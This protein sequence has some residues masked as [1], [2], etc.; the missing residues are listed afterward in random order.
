MADSGAPAAAQPAVVYVD[1]IFDL[2]H[3]GH[4]SFL[5]KAR[6]VGG[7]GATL[8][9]GVITDEDARWKRPPIMT[10]AERLTMVRHCTEVGAVL[11]N[12]PL[13]LTGEFLD[14]HH[15]NFVVHGDDDKQEAFFRVPIERGIMRYVPYTPGVST[16][17]IISRICEWFAAP[18]D[19][20]APEK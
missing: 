8:L 15:I 6:A 16:T 13:V 20:P 12:P 14:A 11:E 4:I 18:A 5:K 2:F 19:A 17:G 9:V 7:A 3:P 10:H 1:G